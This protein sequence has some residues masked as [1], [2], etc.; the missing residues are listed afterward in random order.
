MLNSTLTP[1]AELTTQDPATRWA[2]D[3]LFEKHEREHDS[4]LE[5]ICKCLEALNDPWRGR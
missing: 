4:S 5:E 3:R 1:G 2:L